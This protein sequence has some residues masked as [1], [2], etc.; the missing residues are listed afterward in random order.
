M[1]RAAQLKS[2]TPIP[3][4]HNQ[5]SNH[6]NLGNVAQAV[7][8]K[9]VFHIHYNPRLSQSEFIIPYWK[10]MRSLNKPFSIGMRFRMRYESEDASERR[11]TW[12]NS[13]IYLL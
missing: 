9:T 5:Y 10:F 2:A 6:K 1:R 12:C 11:L 3:I 13:Y 4:L 8:M 7:A